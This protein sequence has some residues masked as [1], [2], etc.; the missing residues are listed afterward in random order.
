MELTVQQLQA[1]CI[2][3]AEENAQLR[4]A[5]LDAKLQLGVIALDNQEP[6]A[7]SDEISEVTNND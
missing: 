3:L 7:H 2:Y 6:K 5:L 4:D 1:K